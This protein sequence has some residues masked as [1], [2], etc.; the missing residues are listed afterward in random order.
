MFLRSRFCLEHLLPLRLFLSSSASWLKDLGQVLCPTQN[1][2]FVCPRLRRRDVTPMMRM[3]VMKVQA[4]KEEGAG[5]VSVEAPVP[6]VRK[7]LVPVPV[8]VPGGTDR[9]KLIDTEC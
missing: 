6:S 2:L 7:N 5:P 9:P 4:N 1:E 3:R 8:P